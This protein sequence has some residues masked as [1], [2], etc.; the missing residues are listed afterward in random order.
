MMD[1]VCPDWDLQCWT[2]DDS[3]DVDVRSMIRART[4]TSW[5][6]DDLFFWGALFKVGLAVKKA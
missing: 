1:R 3:G 6:L 2:F 5:G 4:W